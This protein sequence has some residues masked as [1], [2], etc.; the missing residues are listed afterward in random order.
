M[1]KTLYLLFFLILTVSAL[2]DVTPFALSGYTIT[3]ELTL[4]VSPDTAYDIMTGDISGWWDHHF[5]D[6][7]MAF[8]IEPKPGGG[9]YE[10]FDDKG[11]GV[12]HATVIFADRGK[13]LRFDGPLGM[14]GS[15]FTNVVTWD[16]EKIPEGT[17][18][19][20][21]VN[22]SGQIK[23]GMDK[24]V[25]QVWNHFLTEGLKPYVESGKYLEKFKK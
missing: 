12:K 9:F 22:M 20:L 15:A 8:Y 1:K 2:A 7:P 17:R 6:K 4:P 5:S 16:Y 21:T 18:V 10:I 3:M 25:E 19:K 23:E 11:N 14:T 24:I 13:K